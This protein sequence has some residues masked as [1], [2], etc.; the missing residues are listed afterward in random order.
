MKHKR[1]ADTDDTAF[2]RV[3]R[4]IREGKLLLA[5]RVWKLTPPARV[6][7]PHRVKAYTHQEHA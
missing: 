5:H 6:P 2:D 4:M 3:G 7:E 1:D